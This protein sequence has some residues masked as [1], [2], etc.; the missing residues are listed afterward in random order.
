MHPSLCLRKRE[1]CRPRTIYVFIYM[2]AC[3]RACVRVRV[4]WQLCVHVP[5]P[6]YVAVYVWAR[7]CGDK[8]QIIK[9]HQPYRLK[10]T[11]PMTFYPFDSSSSSSPSL[12]FT[13]SLLAIISF[14]PFSLQQKQQCKCDWLLHSQICTFMCVQVWSEA[15]GLHSAGLLLQRLVICTHS[16]VSPCWTNGATVR[17]PAWHAHWPTDHLS[18]HLVPSSSAKW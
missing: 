2:C 14:I 13:L 4:H 11:P 5:V 9:A 18:T 15:G 6:A 3:V 16:G 8:I 17:P 10:I 12:F 7:L 1:Q